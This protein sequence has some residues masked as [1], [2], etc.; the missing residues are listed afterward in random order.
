[1]TERPII[2]STPM[3]QAI[4][5]GRK[6]QTRRVIKPQLPDYGRENVAGLI[7]FVWRWHPFIAPYQLVSY[8]PYGQPGDTLW[9]RETFMEHHGESKV[10]YRAG[11]SDQSLALLAEFG[12]KWRP[13]I[14]MPRWASRISLTI[15]NVRVE[16]VQEIS[17]DDALAEG[18]GG[19]RY[20]GQGF[21]D[22]IHREA[23]R[24]LWDK[25]NGK[26]YPWASNPWV[27][28]IEFEV[29]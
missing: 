27:W 11:Q 14:F 29:K 10:W 3:V 28:V 25:I 6:T 18:A 22:C 24:T 21:D 26:K 20:R 8:C 2:F 5:E 15:T 9:V 13:S 4:L 7:T 17:E 16:R 19:E 1:M 12:E 23:Y